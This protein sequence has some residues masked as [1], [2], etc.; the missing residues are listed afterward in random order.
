LP[1]LRLPLAGS[2]YALTLPNSEGS[3]RSGLLCGASVAD[4]DE[5][6][7]IRPADHAHNLLRLA[8]LTGVA[9]PAGL[10]IPEGRVGW[11]LNTPDR[12]PLVGAVPL[13]FESLPPGARLDQARMLPRQPGL[14]VLGAL[15]SRGISW[16]PLAAQVL[17][18]WIDGAPLPLESDLLDTIDP[19]RFLVRAHSRGARKLS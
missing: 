1:Q 19:A 5:E 10:P 18:A 7:A 8:Q 3:A 9:L 2:G 14:F 12:L 13:R 4:G 15:G 17:A 16:A 11:R 6:A